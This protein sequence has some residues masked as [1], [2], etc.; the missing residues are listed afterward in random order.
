MVRAVL[1][2]VIAS[3]AV[4]LGGC[5]TFADMMCGPVCVDKKEMNFFYR[6]VRL[7]LEAAK[8][9]DLRALAI[10]DMP[11]S[12]VADTALLPYM[13]FLTICARLDSD[14]ERGTVD[15]QKVV[16]SSRGDEASSDRQE[17]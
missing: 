7:D 15:A 6:G 1:A 11:F 12:A 14:K 3:L 4:C 13:A 10:A 8:E 9:N 2:L 5:G 17:W 16:S